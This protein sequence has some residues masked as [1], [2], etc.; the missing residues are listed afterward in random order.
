[1]QNAPTIWGKVHAEITVEKDRVI[2]DMDLSEFDLNAKLSWHIR[3]MQNR[4]AVR[5]A[6]SSGCTAQLTNDIVSIEA[7]QKKISIVVDIESLN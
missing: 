5:I 1:M 7:N 6:K 4:K 3:N 2:L